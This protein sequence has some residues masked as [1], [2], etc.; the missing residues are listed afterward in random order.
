MDD[1]VLTRKVGPL[2]AIAWAAMV[3]GIYI[4]YR[5]HKA[6]QTNAATTAA[7]NA[8]QTSVP[9]LGTADNFSQGYSNAAGNGSSAIGSTSAVSTL[10]SPL[11]NIDWGK[12]A[13]DYLISLGVNPPDAATAVSSYL[14]NTG[15]QLN[16]VQQGALNTALHQFGTPPEGVIIPP[17]AP[18][19]NTPA[20]TTAVV[21]PSTQPSQTDALMAQYVSIQTDPDQLHS[22]YGR[23][24]YDQLVSS[25]MQPQGGRP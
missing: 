19:A 24:L 11:T 10:T 7:T 22:D 13:Q 16:D 6:A 2:P 5:Y 21:D 9:D 14:Y 3:G 25:G 20:A 17:P 18:P 15:Q 23:S 1:N 8:V 4:V 12:R